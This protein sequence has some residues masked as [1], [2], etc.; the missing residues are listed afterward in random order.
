MLLILAGPTPPLP[1][2]T[3]LVVELFKFEGIALFAPPI[4]YMN[5]TFGFELVEYW[6]AIFRLAEALPVACVGI[7]LAVIRP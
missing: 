4:C 2:D 7:L 3:P 1:T 5:L 6:L